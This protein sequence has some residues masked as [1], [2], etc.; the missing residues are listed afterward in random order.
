MK[1]TGIMKGDDLF[2]PAGEYFGFVKQILKKSIFFK[3]EINDNAR[4]IK[5]VKNYFKSYLKH[6]CYLDMQLSL[7]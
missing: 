7:P 6:W 2:T 3:A 5:G 4:H 1:Y